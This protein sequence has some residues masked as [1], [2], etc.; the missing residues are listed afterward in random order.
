MITSKDPPRD[1]ELAP[2]A[3]ITTSEARGRPHAL[4]VIISVAPHGEL[5][6]ERHSML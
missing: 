5:R 1:V 3:A 6:A 4:E 2:V